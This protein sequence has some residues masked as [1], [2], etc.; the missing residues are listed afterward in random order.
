[1]GGKTK[2]EYG[3]IE[4]KTSKGMID[5]LPL[6]LFHRFIPI[7]PYSYIVLPPTFALISPPPTSP[8]LHLFHLP[9]P[10]HLHRNTHH[11]PTKWNKSFQRNWIKIPPITPLILHLFRGKNSTPVV[12]IFFIKRIGHFSLY[13]LFHS[14][15][16]VMKLVQVFKFLSAK[17]SWRVLGLKWPDDNRKYVTQLSKKRFRY[18]LVSRSSVIH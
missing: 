11:Y 6:L 15:T 8:P 16:S 12:F 1:M 18:L 9:H 10:L 5:P 3:T 13:S 14:R 7:I 4:V 17:I 2:Q